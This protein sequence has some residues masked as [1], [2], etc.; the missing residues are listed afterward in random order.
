MKIMIAIPT[1]RY[2]ETACFES[3]FNLD[4]GGHDV[5]LATVMGYGVD[6]GR[7][8]LSEHAIDNGYDYVLWVDSDM[9]IPKDALVKLLSCDKDIIT[10]LYSYKVLL[11]NEV[12]CLKKVGDKYG[13]YKADEITKLH[14]P[15]EVDAFGFGCCLM[16]VSVL[17][18]A[19]KPRFVFSPELG[20][21]IY[22]CE[23]IKKCG[24]TLYA[25]PTVLCGHIGYVNYNLKGGER[26]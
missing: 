9:I 11:R 15:I 19:E 2:I 7:N 18:E 13:N 1:D 24:Y 12:V 4:R 3:L 8:I 23:K 20:E 26:G 16:K 21:D 22:F 14:E 5:Q 25:D 17:K 10:G 6:A